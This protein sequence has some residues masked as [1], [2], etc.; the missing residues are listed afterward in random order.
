M[1]L[2][3]TRH[4]LITEYCE[5]NAAILDPLTNSEVKQAISQLN[6]KKK[7]PDEFGLTAEHLKYA[8]ISLIKNISD[9]FI[10]II[11]DKRV[12]KAFKT[13]IVTPVLKKSK[14]PTNMDNYRGIT[15]TPIIGECLTATV[16]TVT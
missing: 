12:P 7:A 1:E 6:T 11:C 4:E 5:E 8:G 16:R 3:N 9:T 10:Q 14:D 15:V 2:C 13:G